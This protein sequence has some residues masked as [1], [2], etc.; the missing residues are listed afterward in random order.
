MRAWGGVFF[1]IVFQK[2][3]I[4]EILSEY[5]LFYVDCNINR[6]AVRAFDISSQLVRIR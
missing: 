1:F 5:S 3:R 6:F 2:G 4:L